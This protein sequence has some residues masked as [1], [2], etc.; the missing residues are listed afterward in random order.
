MCLFIMT[1]PSHHMGPG[2]DKDQ[3]LWSGSYR[4]GK[5]V[6]GGRILDAFKSDQTLLSLKQSGYLAQFQGKHS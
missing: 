5:H 3:I 1:P 6:K 2:D 4:I